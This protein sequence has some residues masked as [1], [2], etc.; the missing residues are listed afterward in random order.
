MLV[1]L[2]QTVTCHT[3]WDSVTLHVQKDPI[4]SVSRH[5]ASKAPGQSWT[6][7]GGRRGGMATSLGLIFPPLAETE[8]RCMDLLLPALRTPGGCVTPSRDSKLTTS[9]GMPLLQSIE[10][11]LSMAI[12]TGFLTP[13]FLLGMMM[14]TR[15]E[16]CILESVVSVLIH[17]LCTWTSG[18]EC[19]DLTEVG[20]PKF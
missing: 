15:L 5:A 18:A 12:N 14:K 3:L 1:D 17:F 19:Q 8:R 6:P 13:V 16:N 7:L 4:R 10:R 20:G 2:T 9:G 11:T